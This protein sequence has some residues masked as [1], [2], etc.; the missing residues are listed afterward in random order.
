MSEGTQ[1]TQTA[2]SQ[3]EHSHMHVH[4]GRLVTAVLLGSGRNIQVVTCGNVHYKSSCHG[5]HPTNS[6]TNPLAAKGCKI[7]TMKARREPLN[8]N[9]GRWPRPPSVLLDEQTEQPVLRQQVWEFA[10]SVL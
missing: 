4:A 3:T 8:R 9:T 7:S 5:V 10:S 2:Y 1:S 6:F